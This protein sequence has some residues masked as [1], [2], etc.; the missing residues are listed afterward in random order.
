MNNMPLS[1]TSNNKGRND[2]QLARVCD[3]CEKMTKVD[4][5]QVAYRAPYK[6]SSSYDI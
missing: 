4:H 5:E 2:H 3:M 1:L 6:G